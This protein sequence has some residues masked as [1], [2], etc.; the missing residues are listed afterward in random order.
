MRPIRRRAVHSLGPLFASVCAVIVLVVWPPL[1]A[2]AAGNNC[3]FSNHW[4]A[5]AQSGCC[6]YGT[7]IETTTPAHWSVNRASNS[8]TD[9][10]AWLLAQNNNTIGIEAGYYSGWFMYNN[11]WTNSLVSYETRD[12]GNC[13]G[14]T[15]GSFGPN[16]NV[17][18]DAW[19]VAYIGGNCGPEGADV[20]ITQ[21]RFCYDE[22]IGVNF[23]Q[24]EV[25][26]STA[27]WM[28]GGSGESFTA[29]Y[30]NDHTH[31]YLWGFIN[32][33]VNSPYWIK[34]ANGHTYSNGGY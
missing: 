10:A 23:A 27:T 4:Y 3:S 19:A 14:A 26:E 24:G 7:G 30:S 28:G 34:V 31:W 15:G 20:G 25:T 21:F 16:S 2:E 6:A 5:Q 13:C 29:Y 11:T 8:T 17:F 32:S 18:M 1:L 33:C 9:E 22:P 12:V